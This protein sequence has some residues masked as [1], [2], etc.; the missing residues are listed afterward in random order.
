MPESRTKL[1]TFRSAGEAAP[2][3]SLQMYTIV[4]A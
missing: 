3:S 2:S 4:S 1:S